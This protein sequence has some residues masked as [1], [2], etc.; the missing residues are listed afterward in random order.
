MCVFLSFLLNSVHSQQA[1]LISKLLLN[2]HEG[3]IYSDGRQHCTLA[4]F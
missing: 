3:G 4:I 1:N 2:I